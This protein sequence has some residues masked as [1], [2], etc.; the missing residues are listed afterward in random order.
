MNASTDPCTEEETTDPCR[1]VKPATDP[2]R[3]VRPATD[4]FR[5]ATPATKPCTAEETMDPCM[6]EEVT[7]GHDAK[8]C[9]FVKSRNG[10]NFKK[11]QLGLNECNRVR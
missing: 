6:E 8:R 7:T 10:S 4:P 1:L 2:S 5:L 11:L 9:M 3:L